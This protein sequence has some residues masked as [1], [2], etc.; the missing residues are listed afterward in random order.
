MRT[1]L[2]CVLRG[3][4]LSGCMCVRGVCRPHRNRCPL[5]LIGNLPHTLRAKEPLLAARVHGDNLYDLM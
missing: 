4:V 2:V 3:W 1:T 5:H